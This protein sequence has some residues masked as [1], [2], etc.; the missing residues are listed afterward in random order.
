MK[1][2]LIVY[3]LHYA[4]ESQ[5]QRAY[6]KS[7]DCS[8]CVMAENA[9]EAITKAKLIANNQNIKIMGVANGTHDL[10]DETAPLGDKIMPHRG[11]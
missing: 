8:V 3:Y 10:V 2:P 7:K 5:R 11:W 6:N 4:D 9:K 1:K